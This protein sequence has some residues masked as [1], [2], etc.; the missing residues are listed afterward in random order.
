MN[1][2]AL[3]PPNMQRLSGTV[4]GSVVLRAKPASYLTEAPAPK[5][6]LTSDTYDKVRSNST[7]LTA[8][9]VQ[10]ARVQGERTLLPTLR[11]RRSQW[12]LLLVVGCAGHI[13][14]QTQA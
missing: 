11:F 13:M 7:V 5:P 9:A 6:P 2:S 1:S 14:N 10:A 8:P 4:I 3:Y 12:W